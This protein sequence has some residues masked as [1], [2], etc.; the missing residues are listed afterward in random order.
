MF[1]IIRHPRTHDPNTGISV[2]IVTRDL[3][4]KKPTHYDM[5]YVCFK[6]RIGRYVWESRIK[7]FPQ[8]TNTPDPSYP[9]DSC[10]LRNVVPKT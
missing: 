8:P 6:D 3:T 7:Y 5:P 4:G 2:S 10:L 9:V 1:S